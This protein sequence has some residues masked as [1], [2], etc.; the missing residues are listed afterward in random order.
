MLLR[1][2]H[3]RA[4]YLRMF[5]ALSSFHCAFH[6]STVHCTVHF[7]KHKTHNDL[8]RHTS[9][10]KRQ[11]LAKAMLLFHYSLPIVAIW[12]HLF[13]I[14]K[15]IVYCNSTINLQIGFIVRAILETINISIS[16]THRLAM[17][18]V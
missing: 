11:F 6:Y 7:D 5:R 9:G 17:E 15:S 8:A 3:C 14:F 4:P 18:T 13:E 10:Y 2:S 12:N 16:N 1:N